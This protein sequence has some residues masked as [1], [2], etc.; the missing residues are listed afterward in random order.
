MKIIFIL[1]CLEQGRNGVGDYVRRLAGELMRL[2]QSVRLIA[3]YEENIVEVIKEEQS[4]GQIQIEVLRVPAPLSSA[5]R[6]EIA[7]NF[8]EDFDPEVLSLQY[9]S[10]S[11][12]KKGLPFGFNSNLRTLGKGR[13]WNIMFHELWCGMNIA[14]P[15]K[16]RVLGQLQKFNIWHLIHIL[17]PASVFTSITSY[18]SFLQQIGVSAQVLPIFGNISL[19]TTPLHEEWQEFIKA[20]EINII[21][22]QP[23][24]WLVIGFFGTT[25]ENEGLKKLLLEIEKYASD[26]V[27]KLVFLMIGH[28]RSG[29]L[30]SLIKESEQIKIIKTGLLAD[31]I[32]NKVLKIAQAGILTT[33]SDGLNKSGTAVAWIERGIPILVS[34]ADPSYQKVDMEQM[35]IYKVDN[36]DD[37]DRAFSADKTDNE[38]DRLSKTAKKY[39]ETFKIN[40]NQFT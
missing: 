11:F 15:F 30:A 32:L 3:L 8:V 5:Q 21:L 22:D 16:E 1:G 31:S 23:D 29:D 14:S 25:Y 36:A 39:I 4:D 34:S 20:T 13:K 18:Q 17:K 38:S 33:P 12:D 7:G 24:Q 10:F 40:F 37:I 9:V 6:F 26:Q 27:R 19:N 2:G 28:N 35:N